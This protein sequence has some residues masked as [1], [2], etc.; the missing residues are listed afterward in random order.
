M[1]RKTLDSINVVLTVFFGK[2]T[3]MKKH[4][5]MNFVTKN[6]TL[7]FCM[8]TGDQTRPQGSQKGGTFHDSAKMDVAPPAPPPTLP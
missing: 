4:C 3:V 1:G 6:G 7:E 8:L 5:K 2:I